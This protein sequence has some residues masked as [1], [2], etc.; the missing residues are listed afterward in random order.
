MIHDGSSADQW[1]YVD[2]KSNPLHMTTH[3]LSANALLA[4]ELKKQVTDLLGLNESCWSK[5]HNAL[6]TN[7]HNDLGVTEHKRVFSTELRGNMQ[8][9]NKVFYFLLLP[10]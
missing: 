6:K 4:N 8:L 3:S 1:L 10:T 5:V 9:D 2:S 7:S